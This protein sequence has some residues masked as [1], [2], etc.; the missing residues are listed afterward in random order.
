VSV[1]ATA[2]APRPGAVVAVATLAALAGAAACGALFGSG[3][4][5]GAAGAVLAL[6]VS[7]LAALLWWARAGEKKAPWRDL[8]VA[9]VRP[10]RLGIWLASDIV[11]LLWAASAGSVRLERVSPLWDGVAL[12][13]VARAL[14]LVV[15]MAICGH[16]APPGRRVWAG[17]LVAASVLPVLLRPDWRGA[18]SAGAGTVVA[19]GILLGQAGLPRLAPA[20]AVALPALALAAASW[21][22]DASPLAAASPIASSSMLVALGIATIAAVA[23]LRAGIAR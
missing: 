20:F 3:P 8:A 16:W 11:L 10:P 17:V 12:Y 1:E 4:A 22:P 14:G 19:A 21:L 9:A 2:P 23:A 5:L 6:V 7:P 13:V 18:A 15:A